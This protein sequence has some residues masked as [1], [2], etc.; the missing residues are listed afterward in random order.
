MLKRPRDHHRYA[1]AGVCALVCALA[2]VTASASISLGLTPAAQSVTP[3]SDFDVFVDVLAAGSPFN[4]F[5]LVVSYD[6]AALTLLP[7]VPTTLQQGCLMT[8]ACS[9]ACGNTFHV[10]T[11]AG[12]SI[13]VSDVLL[14]NQVSLT[15]PGH[16]Y[17]LRFHAAVTPQITPLTIRRNTFYNAGLFV[18]PVIASGCLVGIGV[19]VGVDAPRPGS[20]RLVRIEPN[21]SFGRVQFISQDAA[22]GFAT[23]EIADVQGRVVRRLGP[24]WLAAHAGFSWDGHDLTGAR[25]PAG[26]YLV[27][28]QRGGLTQNSRVILRP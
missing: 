14:C 7:T 10:F 22:A 12:D 21:P 17:K 19:Q 6:P 27:R 18:T 1:I 15:G 26:V 28:I 25:V 13:S 24:V 2:P 11:A 20:S 5:D 23:A 4:G 8:G 3:G 16:L 9:G